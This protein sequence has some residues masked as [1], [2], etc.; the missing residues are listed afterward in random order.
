MKINLNSYFIIFT[1]LLITELLIATVFRYSFLRPVFG[2]FLVTPLL[3]TLAR[4]T[5]KLKPK[6]TSFVVLLFALIIELGQYINIRELL[7]FEK[8]WLFELILGTSFDWFD[9]LAY[10]LGVLTIYTVDKFILLSKNT[11]SQP[12][13]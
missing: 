1:F 2:D 5:I 10:T 4:G 11:E 7:G 12:H 8:Q 13:T 9:I 6:T 3:Y